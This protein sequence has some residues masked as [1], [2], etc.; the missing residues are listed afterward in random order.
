MSHAGACSRCLAR[1]KTWEGSN[2]TCAFVE[3]T[4]SGDN[5]MCATMN[6]LRD[7]VEESRVWSED[8]SAAIIPYDG[9][10]IVLGWYKNRGRTEFAGKLEERVMRPLTLE[11]AELVLASTTQHDSLPEDK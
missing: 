2:P 8:Q 6:G 4:F 3:G 7:M 1:G 5:W 9:D 10:F 11:F